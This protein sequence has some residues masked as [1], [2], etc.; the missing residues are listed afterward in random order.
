[1]SCQRGFSLL[2]A[3]IVVLTVS[4]AVPS[5]VRWLTDAAS[6]RANSVNTVRAAALATAV[7]ES[8]IA[9]VASSGPGLGF[10]A[11]DDAVAY[12]TTPVSGLRA[13]LSGVTSAY[14]AIG[15]TYAL[16]V[17]PLLDRTGAINADAGQNVYRKVTVRVEFASAEGGDTI[18]ASVDAL[19]TDL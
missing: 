10:S 13:R 8:V 14:E 16:E 5:T 4:V 18:R 15:F 3:V 2:E 19:V 7:M 6:Q 12:E 11:L 1:M 17:S 9:D